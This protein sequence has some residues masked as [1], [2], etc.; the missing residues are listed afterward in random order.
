LNDIVH[1]IHAA[2]EMGF[3]RRKLEEQR[4]RPQRRKRPACARPMPKYLMMLGGLSPPATRGRPGECRCGSRRQ[5]ARPL[6]RDIDSCGY[7]SLQDD[8]CNYLRTLDR[9]RGAAVASFISVLSCRHAGRMRRL[10]NSQG[11]REQA[12][13]TK[14]KQD[15][16]GAC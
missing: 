11:S 5:S 6:Q 1:R 4:L 9:Y 14:C 3:N 2:I 15:I 12:S 13:P 7:A 10:L 16:V 8:Q